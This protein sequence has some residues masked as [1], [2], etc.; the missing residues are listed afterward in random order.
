MPVIYEA[1]LYRNKTIKYSRIFIDHEPKYVLLYKVENNFKV[2][3][4]SDNDFLD[5]KNL[6]YQDNLNTKIYAWFSYIKNKVSYYK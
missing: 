5:K 3:Y 4:F 6:F 2:I 1:K